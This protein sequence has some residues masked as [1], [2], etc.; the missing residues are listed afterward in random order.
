MILC[1]SHSAA[2]LC[3]VLVTGKDRTLVANIAAAN[4]F[5]EHHLQEEVYYH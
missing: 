1:C 4:N 2:G 3:A 5:K